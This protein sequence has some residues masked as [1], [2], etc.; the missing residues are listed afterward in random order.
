MDEAAPQAA[1]GMISEDAARALDVL[2]LIW[3]DSFI[4]GT[5]HEHGWWVIRDGKI[6]SILTSD[7]PERLGMLLAEQEG[8]GL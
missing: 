6:G 5:D 1:S 7:S 8:T 4:F 2:R 3:G